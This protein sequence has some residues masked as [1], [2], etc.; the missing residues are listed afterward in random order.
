MN[1]NAHL[2]RIADNTRLVKQ[3]HAR[4][5]APR[6]LQKLARADFIAVCMAA[7]RP[8]IV[9]DPLREFLALDAELQRWVL[10]QLGMAHC[11]GQALGQ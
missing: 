6:E 5:H 2:E 4:G 10:E 7:G 11:V 1:N 3:W 8:H 9:P